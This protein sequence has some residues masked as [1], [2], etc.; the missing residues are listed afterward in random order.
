MTPER[1]TWLVLSDGSERKLYRVT[2]AADRAPL[3]YT[4]S[5]K[6]TGL[7]LDKDDFLAWFVTRTRGTT[8]FVQSEPLPI[9]LQPLIDWSGAPPALAPGMLRPVAGTG[10]TVAGGG[11]L[12]SGR[13]SR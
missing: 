7:S 12:A 5:A 6:A 1:F 8:A 4:L 13:P 11:M 2:A 10:E 9:A 3:R